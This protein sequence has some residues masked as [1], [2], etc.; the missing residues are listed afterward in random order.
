MT[1]RGSSKSSKGGEL[2]WSSRELTFSSEI[3]DRRLQPAIHQ[4]KAAKLLKSRLFFK[5]S[6]E[7]LHILV[8]SASN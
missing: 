3:A 8:L 4:E 6:L 5:V 2:A 7:D 1:Q